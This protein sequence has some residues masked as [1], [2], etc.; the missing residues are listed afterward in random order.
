MD[1][2]QLSLAHYRLR[3]RADDDLHLPA[4]PRSLWHGVFGNALRD[5]VCIAPGSDCA[6]CLALHHC[7][8][9]LLFSGP[10]PP[11]SDRMRKYDR[12][13]VPHVLHVPETGSR[14][15][16]Q[17]VELG[18]TL[19]G[20]A[21]DRL[22]LVIHA[23]SRAAANGLGQRRGRA[24]LVEAVQLPHNG[25]MPLLVA[26][27]SQLLPSIPPD[28]PQPPPTPPMLRLHFV[29]P[30]RVSNDANDAG[31]FNVG[32]FL[33][34]LVRRIS[35]LQY[36]YG[37]KALDADF[38]ALKAISVTTEIHDSTLHFQRGQRTAAA[39][40]N[41]KDTGGLSGSFELPL[42]GIEPFWPYLFIGQWL[43]L[44]KNASMGFGQY[45]L[46]AVHVVRH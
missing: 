24:T 42:A 38:Q 16:G 18:L 2:P 22:G 23:L 28:A 39:H 11:G 45:E 6:S 19:I 26:K 3:F 44:G 27:T 17:S 9:S 35:L 31:N 1:Q 33:M 15:R 25:R 14:R 20:R 37:A 32:R 12:I 21:N 29:S 34:T 7:D 10:R 5:L 46:A 36:F 8:Y 41:P 4:Y 30:Y 43:S 40:P 13:P